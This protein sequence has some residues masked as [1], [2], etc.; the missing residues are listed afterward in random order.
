MQKHTGYIDTDGEI[1]LELHAERRFEFKP[2]MASHIFIE[3][4]I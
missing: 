3:R 2:K 1:K 4:E